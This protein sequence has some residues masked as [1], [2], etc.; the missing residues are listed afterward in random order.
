MV[1]D[2]QEDNPRSVATALQEWLSALPSGTA[3]LHEE[4]LEFERVFSITPANPKGCPVEFRLSRYG[5]FGLYLGKAFSV[6]EL[7]C[8]ID[9]VLDICES[10]RRG[11]VKEEVWEW[12]GKV[13]KAKGAVV[14]SKYQIYDEG[15]CHWLGWLPIGTH[16]IIQYEP[17]DSQEEKTEKGGRLNYR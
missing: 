13:I 12:R 14:L 5:T 11:R 16:R 4:E 9:R 17:W 3:T 2:K 7:P 15:S 1:M 8:S 10:L 6:E